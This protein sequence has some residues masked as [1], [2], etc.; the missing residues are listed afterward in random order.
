MLGSKDENI[1]CEKLKKSLYNI[2]VFNFA[3]LIK[4]LEVYELLK[5]CK[6]FIGNDSGLTH[7][8]AASNIKT[9][10]LFGPSKNEIYRP[11][12]KN[13]YFIRTPET[14]SQLVEVKG[15][16]RFDDASLLKSLKVNDVHRI[17]LKILS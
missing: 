17:C 4:V 12:G 3:G 8:A 16:N 13:S 1:N 11:W 15:Y 6:L 2:N 7:L 10:A 14:Y 5:L 9:L